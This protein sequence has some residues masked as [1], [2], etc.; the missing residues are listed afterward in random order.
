MNVLVTGGAGFIGLHLCARLEAALHDVLALDNFSSG[1]APFITRHPP[2]LL[3]ADLTDRVPRLAAGDTPDVIYHLACPAA[4]D[5]YMADAVKTIETAVIG[6]RNVLELARRSGAVV[7]VASTSEVYGSAPTPMR[8]TD[9]GLV[10]PIGPRSCYDEGKRCAEALAAAYRRQYG[11]NAVLVRLFNVYGPGMN[12][13][14]GRLLPNLI[15]QALA[16]EP[17]TVYGDGTQTRSLCYVSDAVAGLAALGRE[18]RTRPAPGGEIPV[19]NLGSDD[20]RTVGEIAEL[21]LK[22]TD[23]LS[24]IT[25]RPLPQDDPP[26][27]RP[28]LE[29]I[30]RLIDWAPAVSLE[31]GIR[32][33]AADFRSRLLAAG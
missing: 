15:R 33:M 3:L 13:D 26:E 30:I 31:T 5:L 14:D 16:G 9:W 28:C 10:N 17:L 32:R 20:E 11:V 18:F 25:H 24:E 8:E 1:K 27:R 12:P 23:S 29:R 4:P 21:V 2:R 19:F 7:V 22:A 6:T